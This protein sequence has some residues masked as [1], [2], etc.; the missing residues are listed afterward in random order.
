M[1]GR[2]LGGLSCLGSWVGGFRSLIWSNP[3][4]RGDV[5][6][7]ANRSS[8]LTLFFFVEPHNALAYLVQSLKK[9]DRT[10]D[11]FEKAPF[12]LLNFAHTLS[13]HMVSGNA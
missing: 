2:G 8:I 6:C 10:A 9:G 13:S 12:H 3:V 7:Y 4:H 11:R 1:G 5:D